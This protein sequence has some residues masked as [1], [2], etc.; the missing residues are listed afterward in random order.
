MRPD[1]SKCPDLMKQQMDNYVNHGQYPCGFIFEV[2][3]CNL[4]EA[5]LSADPDNFA[6]LRSIVK[7]AQCNVPPQM[8][9][10]RKAILKH[11]ESFK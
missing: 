1:P 3:R 4:D 8:R 2:L 10:S 11:I 6:A 9:H 5:V 7:Y